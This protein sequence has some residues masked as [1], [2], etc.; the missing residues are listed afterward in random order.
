MTKTFSEQEVLAFARHAYREGNAAFGVERDY[1][2]L[3]VIDMQEEFVKPHSTPFWVPEATRQVPLIKQLIE[4]CRA[5]SVP[6]I[7]TAFARTHHY[8]DRP[9]AGPL[10]PNR[11]AEEDAA[12]FRD[13]VIWHELAPLEDEIVLYKPSYGAFYDTPLETI[14]KNLHR[15][16]V[17][18]CGTLTNFCCGT[19][20]RQAYERG[21]KVIFGSDIT[22]TDDPAMQEPELQVLRKGF[23]K[24]LFLDEILEQIS[25]L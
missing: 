19:T 20:A 1:C 14:L 18:I 17:I 6:V 8:L 5:K 15:D 9:L 25:R 23:A 22:A 7:Y 2:A 4:A 10:M 13:G 16:T 11:Y 12:W 21:F 24:V 3:L